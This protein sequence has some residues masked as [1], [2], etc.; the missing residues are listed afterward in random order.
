MCRPENHDPYV[1]NLAA[2]FDFEFEANE[3]GPGFGLRIAWS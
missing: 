2:L 3:G 1:K